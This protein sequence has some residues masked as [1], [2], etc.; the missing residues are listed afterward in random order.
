MAGK[1]SIREVFAVNEDGTLV[2]VG[3]EA[4]REDGLDPA[5]YGLQ[6]TEI[7]EDDVVDSLTL[8]YADAEEDESDVEVGEGVGAPCEACRV[9]TCSKYPGTHRVFGSAD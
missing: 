6:E 1:R 7:L 5:K 8:L 3:F 9:C 4:V 2:P